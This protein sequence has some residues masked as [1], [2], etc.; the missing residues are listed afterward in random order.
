V[1]VFGASNFP[2]AFSTAGG[3]TISALAAGCSV[4]YKAHPAHPETS[5][6]V[7]DCIHQALSAC[8]LPTALFTH[9]EG[10]IEEGQALV[11]HPVAKAI[12]FTGSH[13]GGMAL[14]QLANQREEPIP[15]FAEMGSVNPIFC[16]PEK[17]ENETDALAKAF[18]AS[19]TL[20]VGQFC[21]NPGMIFVPEK[22]AE[23]FERAIAAEL[24]DIASAPMLHPGIAKAYYDSLQLLEARN[25]L[26]WVKAAD[27]RHLINGSP[28]LAE[29]KAADWLKDRLFQQEVFGAFAFLVVYRDEEELLKIAQQLQ[30]QLTIT[31]WAELE[32]LKSNPILVNLLQEKCGRLLFKGAPTGVEVGHAMQH[33]GPFPATTAPNSTSVG[34]YAI[35]RFA[36]PIAFQDMPQSLLPEALMDANPLGIW[37]TV[38]GDLSK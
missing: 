9:I 3:D 5:R 6:K 26:R 16:L 34:T 24:K 28:A 22:Q 12:A 30:G 18:V 36:R 7:A 37:R 38:N 33:G 4:I 17:L 21:T 31:V 11:Q 14:F 8:G 1:V 25:E 13:T 23:K 20:G 29:I 19:L 15:V 35:K 2:L 32:E 27:S 10:G